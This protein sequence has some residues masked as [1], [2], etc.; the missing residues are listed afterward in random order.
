MQN[1]R[2][3]VYQMTTTALMTAVLCIL[4]PI[5][6]PIGAV[7]V[8]FTM[9]AIYFAVYLIGP[10]FGTISYL[11]Y[12]L[13][14]IV[15]LPV[16]SGYQGGPAK[17][18]G[19]TGGYLVGFI[20]T[21]IVAGIVID[22]FDGKILPSICGMVVGLAASYV[23][24]TIWFILQSGY[25]LEAALAACVFPFLIFDTI[26]ILFAALV[27]PVIRKQLQKAHLIKTA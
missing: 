22:K 15:G 3:T 17:L 20:I 27:G 18:A 8:S 4:G 5:S 19:P 12:L 10:K 2:L 9:V 7:P 13:I 14:G 23:L 26:K 1:K 24:G 21:A 11:L 25:T 6:V 16:F